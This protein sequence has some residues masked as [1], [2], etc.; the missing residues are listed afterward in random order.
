MNESFYNL[1]LTKVLYLF[2]SME[3]RLE[4]ESRS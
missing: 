2:Q 3:I 1:Y 4:L